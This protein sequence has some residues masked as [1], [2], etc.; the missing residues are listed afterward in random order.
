[1][2]PAPFDRHPENSDLSK[3]GENY[4]TV[5]YEKLTALLIEAVK[6][7]NK[8]VETLEYKLSNITGE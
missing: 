1:M 8:K 5:Q 3:T 6:D 4:L 2:R 7:L